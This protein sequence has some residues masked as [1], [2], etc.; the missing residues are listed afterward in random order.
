MFKP[1]DSFSALMAEVHADRNITG[2]GASTANRFPVRFVLFDNFRDCCQFVEEMM[3]IGHIQIQRLEDWMDY[4]YPDTMLTHKRLA[5]RIK[6]LI[7]KSPAEYR[8]IMPLSELA[9]FYNNESEHAE[10]N[11]LINTVKGFDSLS[12]GYEHRQRVYIPIVGLEGKMQHFR[13]DSQSFIWY[14]HNADHQLDYRLILTNGT[15]YGVNGLETKYDVAE[16][17]LKWLSFWKYPELK[18]YIISTSPSIYSHE[19]YAK[20]DNAFSFCPCKNSH[21]FLTKGLQLDLDS[22]PYKE[23]E[24]IYWDQLA[25]RIDVHNFKFETFFNEQFGIFNLADYSVFF[26]QWFKNKQPFMRWLL[27]K[28]YT[29]KFCDEGYICRV[30]NQ[31][32]GYND[33]AFTKSLAL[34]IF[35]LNNPE[36]YLEERRLGLSYAAKNGMDL[37]PE[38]QKFL[39]DKILEVA[40]KDGF[41]SALPYISNLSFEEKA[42]VI[43]WYRLGIIPKDELRHL[44]PDLFFYLSNTIASTEDAWT[45]DYFDKYKE[46]KISNTYTDIVK[47]YI[48][49]KNRNNLE[50]HKWSS[51][52]STTRTILSSRTDIQCFFWIDGLGVEWLPFIE[53]VVAEHESD[54]YFVNEAFIATS[55]LPTRTDINRKDIELISNGN[56]IKAG[57]LDEIA[58]TC[59]P[60]P[61]YIIDD[62]ERVRAMIEKLLNDHPGEKIAILSDHGISYLSQLVQGY[63]LQGYQ[64][65]HW[66][67]IAE[68]KKAASQIVAD[69]KY[70][71]I[72]LQDSDTTYLCS[73]KHESL[74][75]KVPEG[76]GCHGGCTPEEQL[77]PII[78]VSPQKEAATWKASLKS[79]IISEANPVAEF[80]ILGLDNSQN[81]IVEYNNHIYGTTHTGTTYTSERMTLSNEAD[82][83]T[84]RIGTQSQK[85][86]VSIALAVQEED[87]FMF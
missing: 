39:V 28:Y 3:H 84:L 38:V 87:P 42:L 25:Q 77:V 49:E 32:D 67:R 47:G 9:R 71:V 40:Q 53:H 20:P 4:E 57:D 21:E 54:G 59:R 29:H 85:F 75:K 43:D 52:F 56:Y 82:E 8:I 50:H 45:L 78:I 80:T 68:T 74:L 81:P 61:K 76:M 51:K 36:A 1:F 17:F 16:N 44:Y 14:F 23:E 15:T 60:Y 83:I 22:I 62:I 30:L 18:R 63:N 34:T 72:T 7:Q 41:L 12:S 37:S 65:D 33:L 73:L 2:D 11:T 86:K 27:S 66:G 58:H 70:K 19:K 31:M 55:K 26:E 35:S 48:D 5:D 6:E 79:F 13:D 24:S 69:D 46:A 10:F 64:S